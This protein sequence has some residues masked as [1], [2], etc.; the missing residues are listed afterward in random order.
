[1]TLFDEYILTKEAG[2]GSAFAKALAWSIIGPAILTG[3]YVGGKHV[4][5]AVRRKQGWKKLIKKYPTLNN[6]KAKELYDVFAHSDPDLAQ[7]PVVI[8][9][10]I[11]RTLDYDE[12]VTPQLVMEMRRNR[13]K[14]EI[15]ATAAR[16][17]AK[18]SVKMD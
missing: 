12:G 10:M 16:M 6:A 18:P 9:P 13:P 15:F 17:T 1:M 4:Y 3:T 7:H 14:D 2:V 8:G 11:K 5:E